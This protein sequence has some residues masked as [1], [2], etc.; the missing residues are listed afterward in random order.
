MALGHLYQE[1]DNIEAATIQYGLIK[2]PNFKSK[3]VDFMIDYE[4]LKK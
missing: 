3:F 1:I 4:K 2:D